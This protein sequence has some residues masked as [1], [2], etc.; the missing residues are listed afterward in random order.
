MTCVNEQEE[1]SGETTEYFVYDGDAAANWALAK[2]TTVKTPDPWFPECWG[3]A[4]AE[5]G[6]TPL[7]RHRANRGRICA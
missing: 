7:L 5:T 4:A 2:T 6:E 3:R 1:H